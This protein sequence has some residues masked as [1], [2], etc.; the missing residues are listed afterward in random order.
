MS[1][2]EVKMK[3]GRPITS[4]IDKEIAMQ[5]SFDVPST[6]LVDPSNY[7]HEVKRER[8][9]RKFRDPVMSS[10][11][12]SMD[13]HPYMAESHDLVPLIPDTSPRSSNPGSGGQ[14]PRS[15]RVDL[16]QKNKVRLKANF[17][18][19]VS[20]DITSELIIASKTVNFME[21]SWPSFH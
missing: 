13:I 19:S 15:S 5:K 4:M 11:H 3:V 7:Q 12:K 14:T 17:I 10:T 6:I 8:A 18:K 9:P 2:E 20:I 21:C 16:H 1:R